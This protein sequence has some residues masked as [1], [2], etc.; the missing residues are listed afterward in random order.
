MSRLISAKGSTSCHRRRSAPSLRN[1]LKT[2]TSSSYCTTQCLPLHSRRYKRKMPGFSRAIPMVKWTSMD[3]SCPKAM[4]IKYQTQM[5][6]CLR[7]LSMGPLVPKFIRPLRRVERTKET[8]P[9]AWEFEVI[10][11]RAPSFNLEPIQP[12]WN[13]NRAQFWP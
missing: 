9:R 8:K 4:S 7:Q 13:I 12:P 5:N 1:S 2:S 11:R 10:D 6:S 3:K